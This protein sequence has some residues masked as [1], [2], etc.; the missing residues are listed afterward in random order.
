LALLK[1]EDSMERKIVDVAYPGQSERV[2]VGLG[3]TVVIVYDDGTIRCP[4][5]TWRDR[6]YP[7]ATLTWEEFARK[8]HGHPIVDREDKDRLGRIGH[9]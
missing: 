1:K 3:V 9:R 6:P 5:L 4:S 7:Q 2:R 8:Y